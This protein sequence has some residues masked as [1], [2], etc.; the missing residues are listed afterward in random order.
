MENYFFYRIFNL[1]EFQAL[2]LVSKTYTIELEDIGLKD[3]LVT[4]GNLVSITYEGVLLSLNLNG[5][6][7]FEFDDHAI[8]LLDDGYVYLGIS[9]DQYAS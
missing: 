6:N 4:K 3:I 2:D 5:A 7:P 9:K 8:V 1:A